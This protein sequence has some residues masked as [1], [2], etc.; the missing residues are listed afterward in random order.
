MKTR[1]ISSTIVYHEESDTMLN[2]NCASGATAVYLL[3]SA[4]PYGDLTIKKV[5]SGANAITIYPA[6]GETIDGASSTTIDDYNNHKTFSPVVGG[7]A[8]VDAYDSTSETLITPVID[9]GDAGVTLTSANQTNAAAVV[10]IP[11]IGDAADTFVMKDTAQTLTNKTLTSP[12]INTPTIATASIT[13]STFTSSKIYPVAATNVLSISGVVIDGE[14]V[15]IGDDVYE[16]CADAAQSL[17]AGSTIAVDISAVS[18]ASEGTLTMDTNPTATN[19]MTIGTTEY[20][21]V[22]TADFDTAGE[23]EIGEDVAAT[24]VNTVAAVNGTDGVNTAHTL[25]TMAAFASDD[26]VITAKVG[27]VA[28]DLIATTET[29]TAGSNIFDGVVLGTTT[30]GVDC[31]APAAVTALALAVTTSDT[32]GVGATDSTGDTV[33]L[34]AD[35]AG[36]AG[37]AIT[38]TETMANGVFAKATLAYGF[39]NAM[40]NPKLSNPITAITLG[41][42]S[43]ANGHADWT[44]T[45]AEL[46]K[47]M[48]IVTLADQAANM[49]IPLTPSIPYTLINTSGQA[50]TVIGASGT[51]TAIANTKTATVMSDGTNVIRLTTDA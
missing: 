34:T 12:T 41:T 28:G 43:Y 8:V 46:Q 47:P 23:I 2:C 3:S 42:H 50:I 1:N 24:Q 38:T 9:D 35:T 32:E 22:A 26:A 49:I 18:T 30:A 5:D 39:D 27:G 6:S 21:F 25:V 15:L 7:W 31:L 4:T 13:G 33:L 16:F 48:H 11:D 44:L 37:N 10:T 20:T 29:F 40:V 36:L 14:T 51:G 45:A 17:T 19:T